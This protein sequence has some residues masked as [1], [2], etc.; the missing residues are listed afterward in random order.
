[1]VPLSLLHTLVPSLEERGSN[2]APHPA[3]AAL[4]GFDVSVHLAAPAVTSYIIQ[5]RE[6]RKKK[7]KKVNAL[8]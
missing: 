8:Q 3:A 7:R 2:P 5:E 6:K 4:Q 1:M